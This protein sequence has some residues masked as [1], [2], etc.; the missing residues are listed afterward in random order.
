MSKDK[1]LSCRKTARINVKSK[2]IPTSFLNIERRMLIGVG[3]WRKRDS[4][5]NWEVIRNQ[6]LKNRPRPEDVAREQSRGDRVIEEEIR[7]NHPTE[8]FLLK[9]V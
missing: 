8:Y 1:E 3:E 9:K 7:T 4:S 6:I 5:K 2:V